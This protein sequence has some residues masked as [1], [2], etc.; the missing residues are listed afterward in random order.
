MKDIN[1][2]LR[3]ACIDKGLLLREISKLV[4]INNSRFSKILH[5]KLEA[6]PPE[7]RRLSFLLRV[8]QKKLF[9]KPLTVEEEDMKC[10]RTR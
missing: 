1:K 6:R 3:K 10:L 7:K 2:S 9:G 5:N 8:S 4:G